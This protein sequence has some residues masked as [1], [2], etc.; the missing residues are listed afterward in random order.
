MNNDKLP[1]TCKALLSQDY[2]VCNQSSSAFVGV[3][4]SFASP[5]LSREPPPAGVITTGNR[6]ARGCGPPI[7]QSSTNDKGSITRKEGT[8]DINL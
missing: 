2:N 8:K 6:P 1:G 7:H 5:S 4:A 3:P